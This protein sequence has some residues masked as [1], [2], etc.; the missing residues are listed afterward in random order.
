MRRTRQR[1]AILATLQD[2]GRPLT[3][4]EI[5]ELASLQVQAINLATVYRNL[6]WMVE[7]GEIAT[8]ECVGQPARYEA[9]GLEHH[10]HFHCETCDQMFDLAGCLWTEFKKIVPEHF[11]VHHHHL[12]L[13][14]VCS[15]CKASPADSLPE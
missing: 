3:P 15:N 7:A 10:H 11:E 12:Q 14:G 5:G 4:V 6:K 1:E 8:V 13:S 2:A 9:A